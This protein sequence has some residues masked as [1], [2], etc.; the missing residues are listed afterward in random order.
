MNLDTHN[1]YFKDIDYNTDN[2]VSWINQPT[3]VVK[4]NGYL[5]VIDSIYERRINKLIEQCHHIRAVQEL[6]D[7]SPMRPN[8]TS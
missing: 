4:E 3:E 8:G 1:R 5:S 2:S 7:E 6:F